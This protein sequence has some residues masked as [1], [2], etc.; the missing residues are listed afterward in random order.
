MPAA[1]DKEQLGQRRSRLHRLVAHQGQFVLP[2]GRWSCLVPGGVDGCPLF[3]TKV[4][5]EAVGVC[6][7]LLKRFANLELSC[8]GD[9]CPVSVGS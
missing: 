2:G 7:L 3:V 5:N 8:R 9:E 1:G 4:L 6:L